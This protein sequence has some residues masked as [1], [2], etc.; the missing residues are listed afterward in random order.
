[1]RPDH[2]TFDCYGTL[3]DWN[4]GIVDAFRRRGGEL[5]AEATVAEILEAYHQA[6]PA[7]ESDRYRSYRE[8]LTLLEGEV[9]RRLGWPEDAVQSRGWLAASVSEWR[10]FDD[11]NPA[12]QRLAAMG[13]RTGIVSNIDDDLLAG[14]RRHLSVAFDLLVTAELVRSYKPAPAHFER[15]LQEVGGD[16]ERVLHVAQSWF[17]DVRP[18]TAMG[19]AVIWVN[20]LEEERPADEPGP[21]AEVPDLAA[22][23]DWIEDRCEPPSR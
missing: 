17:H 21:E 20:R 14:T 9:C 5:G 15:L 2:V 1:M 22:A 18:A 12:L 4:A 11:T 6:E 3:V 10:P 19:I 16:P 23:V 13:Y 7:L 8:V